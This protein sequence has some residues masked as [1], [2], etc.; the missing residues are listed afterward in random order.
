M[1]KRLTG[2]VAG[3]KMDK[4]RRVEV[5]RTVRHPKYGKIVRTTMVCH[6]HDENNESH[7]GDVVEIV[8]CRPMS[9]LKRWALVKIV[10]PGLRHAPIDEGAASEVA[11][12]K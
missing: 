1:R 9:R 3:D 5:K 4:S 12:E 11:A 6:A 7:T 10:R 2:T 8:E